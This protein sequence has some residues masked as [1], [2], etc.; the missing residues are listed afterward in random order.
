[1]TKPISTL[2]CLLLS[3]SICFA[4]DINQAMELFSQN[5]R[6]ES[7]SML[8]S[9]VSDKNAGND[10]LLA[11]TVQEIDNEHSEQALIYFMQF[12]RRHP[13]PYPYAYALWNKGIFNL[14]SAP[15]RD[16]LKSLMNFIL[17]DPHANATMR[18]AL[19]Q[20]GQQAG[21]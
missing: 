1:M 20:P 6:T 17:D 19:H 13:D 8:K 2:A 10:A 18:M 12:M 14:Q 5:K 16:T 9:L 3:V 21:E 11:L 7:M 4:Q 15:A